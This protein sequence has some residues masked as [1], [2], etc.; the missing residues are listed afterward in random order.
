MKR[1]V[2]VPNVGDP[3]ELIGF[4]RAVEDAGWD[5][6]FLWDH[7]QVFAAAGFAVVDPW[8]V[9][10]G[11]A[12]ATES[13]LLGPMVT[14]PS[15]RRPWQLGKQIVTLDHL[16]GGRVVVGVGLG[17]PEE[18]EFAAFGE[19][20]DVRERA[21][22]TDEA[23]EIIDRILRGERIDHDGANYQVHAQLRPPAVQGPRPPLWVAATPPHRKPLVRAARWD[24]VVCNVKVDGDLMPL[25]P[26]ELKDYVGV[27]LD[28]PDFDVVTNAHPDHEPEEYEAIGVS[29]LMDTCWPGPDW[30]AQ[31]RDSL[32]LA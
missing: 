21:A 8:I 25:R 1:A 30:L 29:W 27:L 14:T 12:Q 13:V 2:S 20:T 4:A 17:F 24:G 28:D 23:L 18:D 26:D 5:G 9:L 32:G 6:F 7:V 19:V 10:A 11:A 3:A 16:S 22:R 15:R 31:F